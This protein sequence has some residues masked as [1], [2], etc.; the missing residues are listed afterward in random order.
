MLAH[1][2]RFPCV[3]GVVLLSFAAALCQAQQGRRDVPPIRPATPLTIDGLGKGAVAL[4]GPW[5]FH[6]GDDP[7]WAAPA[8]DDSNWERIGGDRPW[9]EQGHAGYTGFA[10]YRISLALSPASGIAPQFK[11]LAPRIDDAYEIYWNGAQVGG[12]GRLP[13]YPVWYYSQAAQSYDLGLTGSGV[14]AVRVWKSPLLSDDSWLVGGFEAAPMIGSPEAIARAKAALEFEWLHG[15][16][17]IFSENLLFALVGLFSFLVWRR[18]RSQWLLFWMTG[19]ALAPVLNVLL[20]DAHFGLPYALAMGAAQPLDSIHD[21]S[22]WF[23]L[24]WLLHLH[25]NRALAR[26][27]RVLACA[28]VAAGTLDGLVVAISGSPRWTSLTLPADGAITAFNTLIDALPIVLVGFAFYRRRELDSARWLVAIVAFLDE[29]IVVVRDAAEQGRQFTHWTIASRIDAVLF[30]LD[31]NAISIDTVT[32]ALLIVSIVYA[33][34]KSFNEAQNRQKMLEQEFGSAQELQRLLIPEA[35]PT[36]PGF[37]L[38]SCYR[39]AQE[40]GGDFFQLIPLEGEATGSVLLI[41]GDVSGKGLQAAMSVSLIVG[42]MRALAEFVSG[43]A[44]MLAELNHS[45]CGRLRGGFVT[46]L[47]LRLD[48]DG[49]CALASA[50]HPAPFLNWHELELPGE[51]PLGL[52]PAASYEQTSLRLRGGDQLVLYTDGLLEARNQSGELY[53]FERLQSLFATRPSASEAAEAA[54]RFGQDDDITV[55]TLT[56]QAEAEDCPAPRA[57]E[58]RN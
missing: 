7:G 41:L 37:A 13:P 46:C 45:L 27:T 53:G 28:R 12:N 55:V 51:L 32:N 10:W 33:V 11:L 35:Q 5:R 15:R 17:F 56:R 19:F 3:A 24:L 6:P 38:T 40:V 4:D 39:P 42:A 50:G 20:L 18:N 30:M 22:L 58:R 47:A 23:L 31:G 14:L 43:P 48:R 26:L 54:I 52:T 49:G 25:E 2:S 16:Q 21:I 57:E 29:M 36:L 9:G 8:F 1:V 44:Q 34:Y